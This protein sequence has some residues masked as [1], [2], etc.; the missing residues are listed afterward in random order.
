MVSGRLREALVGWEFGAVGV[1]VAVGRIHGNSGV[2]KAEKLAETV[3]MIDT[4]AQTAECVSEL[5]YS[6]HPTD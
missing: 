6:L 5:Y 4:E 3:G 1:A 2:T